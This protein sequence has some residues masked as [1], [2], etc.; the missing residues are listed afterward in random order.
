MQRGFIVVFQYT[1]IMYFDQIYRYSFLPSFSS[2]PAIICL[3]VCMF[4]TGSCYAAQAG[5]ELKILLAQPPS[6]GITGLT[7]IP[8]LSYDF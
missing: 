1:S 6:A 3:L 7:I 2:P 8:S 5:L 4:E